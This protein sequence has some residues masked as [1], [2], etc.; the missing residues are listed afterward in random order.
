VSVVRSSV[1]A[2]SLETLNDFAGL[3]A[4]FAHLE[5][6]FFETSILI[7]KLVVVSGTLVRACVRGALV[8]G[9]G[10]RL[11][12]LDGEL[13]EV[14][15]KSLVSILGLSKLSL[16]TSQVVLRAFKASHLHF[17]LTAHSL[18]FLF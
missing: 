10:S 14:G 17:E 7:A 8:G 12:H 9:H 18:V 2:L 4:L 15:L 11:S 1:I 6:S 5:A 16:R 3:H 13:G